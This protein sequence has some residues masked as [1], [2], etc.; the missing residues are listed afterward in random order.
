[1][2]LQESRSTKQSELA[3]ALRMQWYAISRLVTKLELRRHVTR[4]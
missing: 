4:E 1:M 2:H 3:E